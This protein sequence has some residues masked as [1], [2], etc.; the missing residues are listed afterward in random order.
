MH[1][2]NEDAI[3]YAANNLHFAKYRSQGGSIQRSVHIY[4]LF[5]PTLGA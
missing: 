5:L 2:L 1:T 4:Q 3:E